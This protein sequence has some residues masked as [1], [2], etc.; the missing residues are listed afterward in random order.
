MEKIIYI[1]TYKTS[2]RLRVKGVFLLIVRTN[3]AIGS[4]LKGGKRLPI[5]TKY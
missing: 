4:P 1:L 3:H 2:L 5:T